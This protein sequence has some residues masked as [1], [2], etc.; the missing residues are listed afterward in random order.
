MCVDYTSLNKVC[1]KDPF[2]LPRIDQVVDLTVGCELLTFLDAYS[3][4]HQIPLAEADQPATMFITNYDYFCYV[5]MSFRL[6]NAG[7]TYQ[8]CMQFCYRGQ[9]GRN[10]EV[11]VDNIMVKYQKSGSLISN[12]EEAFNN[13]WRFNIKLNS[14]KRTFKILRGKLLGY[15]ITERSIKANPDK[16]WAIVEMGQVRN[17]KDI[18]RLMGC[19]TALIHFVSQLGE[20]RL[21]LYKLLKKSDSFRWTEKT[22]KTLDELKTLITKQ[23]VLAL[24][25]PSEDPPPVHAGNHPGHQHGPGGGKGGTRARL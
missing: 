16:I 18:Q 4:Y 20:C 25:E 5:K 7:D 14:V 9:I 24:L 17:V 12:I 10:L 13:L 2:P 1:L 15:I 6:K 8:Q 19:L 22:Q 3:G 11:Y 21:P 23:P